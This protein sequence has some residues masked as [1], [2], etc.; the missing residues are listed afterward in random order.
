M[1][2]IESRQC[3]DLM[4]QAQTFVQR[5][6]RK[7]EEEKE[8]R[9]KQEEERRLLRSK[10]EEEKVRFGEVVMDG[11]VKVGSFQRVREEA[12][13]KQLEEAQQK[14]KDFI[15][16]MKEVCIIPDLP[17]EEKPKRSK[18][19]DYCRQVGTQGSL[20]VEAISETSTSRRRSRRI[21]QRQ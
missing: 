9:R 4:S 3:N 15:E 12:I 14:R 8:L 20:S 19:R 17:D 6:R 13:R 10:Q 18:V 1:S 11:W 2:S 5:A 21:R 16:K 7:D